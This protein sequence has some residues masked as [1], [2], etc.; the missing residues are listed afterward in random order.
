[1]LAGAALALLWGW[2]QAQT[3]TSS[4]ARRV[5]HA[6]TLPSTCAVGDIY[7]DDNATSGS[8][9]YLC[10]TLN[11]WVAVG[12]AG[13]G[14]TPSAPLT[15]VQFNSSGTFGGSQSL[16]FDDTLDILSLDADG[17]LTATAGYRT[18]T[19][20]FTG[21]ADF[22]CA[23]DQSCDLCT[24]NSGSPICVKANGVIGRVDL[25]ASQ[26]IVGDGASSEIFFTFDGAT[27]VNPSIHWFSGTD[28]DGDGTVGRFT[29]DKELETDRSIYFGPV[30]SAARPLVFEGTTADA[31]ETVLT[32]ADPL[33][34]NTI[35][36]VNSTGSV[37]PT[38]SCSNI[39]ITGTDQTIS[40]DG[41]TN[42]QVSATGAGVTMRTMNTCDAANRGRIFTLQCSVFSTTNAFTI[43]DNTGNIQLGGNSNYTCNIGGV[44]NQNSITFVC[45]GTKWRDI[46]GNG[47][48]ADGAGLTFAGAAGG[49]TL[50]TAS[51]EVNFLNDGGTTDLTCP[52]NAGAERVLDAGTASQATLQY[53]DGSTT[54]VRRIYPTNLCSVTISGVGQTV[55]ADNC[56]HLKIGATAFTD[57]VTN[58]NTCAVSSDGRQLAVLC[59]AGIGWSLIDGGNLKLAGNFPCSNGVA[60]MSAI[61]LI[62]DG[63]QG[64]WRE[65]GR[66]INGT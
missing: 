10:E 15:S 31:N 17:T 32:V 26:V 14:G 3:V 7:Q 19:G 45:D 54:T 27:A 63:A 47:S 5:R 37:Y 41:C 29:I 4:T 55:T 36:L 44:D 61:N 23:N 16:V 24:T 12:T 11:T 13:G 40:V 25:A 59:N 43:V 62:C 35:T 51:L 1:L 2:L 50:S 60:D 48:F 6:P 30:A 49:V 58:I 53:C 9:F 39:S 8:Q 42:A 56:D 64:V 18:G 33:A 65:T 21:N 57:T 28:N 46:G 22:Q 52:A 66:S 20:T 38:N 34:D